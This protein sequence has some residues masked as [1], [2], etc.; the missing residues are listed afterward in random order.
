MIRILWICLLLGASLAGTD[1]MFR[2]QLLYQRDAVNSGQWHRLLT[3]HFTHFTLYH[4]ATNLAGAAMAYVILF[5]RQTACFIA[6]MVMLS[7]MLGA[8]LHAWALHLSVYAGFSGVLHGL[9]VFGILQ[10]LEVHRRDPF[11]WLAL[12]AVAGKLFY[13]QS[14]AFDPQAFSSLLS[15]P[16]ATI[17]HWQGAALG[18]ISGLLFLLSKRQRSLEK[19]QPS[20]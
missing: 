4:L 5:S 18:L 2:D 12:A 6:A 9:V 17:A 20:Q 16:V 10:Q 1:F 13:E 14:S 15:V 19:R 8:G 7:V 11:W 3:C